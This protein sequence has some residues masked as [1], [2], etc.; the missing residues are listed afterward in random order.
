MLLIFFR[1]VYLKD[2][3]HS[4]ES[5]SL[6]QW[7]NQNTKEITMKQCPL[8]KTPILKTQRFMNQ[9]KVILGDISKIKEK[10]LG[11]LSVIKS[12]M[13]KMLKSFKALNNKFDSM[14]IGDAKE[15]G[16]IKDLWDKLCQPLLAS[17]DFKSKKRV[18]FILPPKVIESLE[19]VVYLFKSTSE[20]KERIR[21]IK[22][23][24]MRKKII[25]HFVWL[26]SVA[27]KYARQLSNQQKSDINLEMVRGVR[28][29]SLFEIQS[30][31]EFKMA[32]NSSL[33]TELANLESH[34]TIIL[35]SCQTYSVNKDENVEDLIKLITQKIE[36]VSIITDAEKKMIH[37][38]MSVNFHGG[39]K[40]QGHWL[41]C[42][43]GH[44]YCITECGGP[45]EKSF[46]PEC[47]EEIG[48]NDHSY[49]R[50]ATVATEMDGS[51]HLAWSSANNLGN[52]IFN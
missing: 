18:N 39:S 20:Y 1:F 3:G 49:V 22:D 2:C 29:L 27:F 36:C 38:A 47:K 16:H 45:M 8:C 19:F 50:E 46:C 10:Q 6:E 17:L 11:E 5:K 9:V 30:K 15:F 34:M 7:M 21:D 23:D 24:K 41:K 40:A 42:S 12:H 4:I 26:L 44:I 35:M 32:M 31:S 13:P 28:I 37:E 51:R 43:K 25:N 48:G 33:F 14:F 52:Y